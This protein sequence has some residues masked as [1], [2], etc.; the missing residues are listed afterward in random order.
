MIDLHNGMICSTIHK[1][2]FPGITTDLLS[3]RKIKWLQYPETFKY[4]LR[5]KGL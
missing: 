3:W 5:H 1:C 2:Y 4:Q